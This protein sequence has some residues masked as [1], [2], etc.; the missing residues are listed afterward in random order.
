MARLHCAEQECLKTACRFLACC[1]PPN[2]YCLRKANVYRCALRSL[3]DVFSVLDNIDTIHLARP[4]EILNTIK[5]APPEQKM[6]PRNVPAKG[7]QPMH[8]VANGQAREIENFDSFLSHKAAA[9]IALA[10]VA[11]ALPLQQ[12]R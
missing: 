10:S 11:K 6:H 5:H 4:F 9:H 12:A 3:T 8:A 1:A 7:L 2:H